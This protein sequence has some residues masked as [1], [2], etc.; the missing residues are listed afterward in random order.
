MVTSLPQGGEAHG[1]PELAADAGVR[2]EEHQPALPG[3]R[4]RAVLTTSPTHPHHNLNS[5]THTDFDC[6]LEEIVSLTTV[7]P[8]S[9]AYWFDC[10]H[11]CF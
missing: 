2:Q 11:S 4:L 1:T 5:Q 3:G 6:N 9:S 10:E 8:L 7:T